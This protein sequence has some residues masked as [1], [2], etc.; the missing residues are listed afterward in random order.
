M[1]PFIKD[2]LS[3]LQL[4]LPEC[5]YCN[6]AKCRVTSGWMERP[7]GTWTGPRVN[8]TPMEVSP[9]TM[10]ALFWHSIRP[11]Y[12]CQQLWRGKNMAVFKECREAVIIEEGRKK[13]TLLLWRHLFLTP[14]INTICLRI[15]LWSL[16][17]F[18]Q[19]FPLESASVWKGSWFLFL[20][21]FNTHVHTLCEYK[22][23]VNE[24]NHLAIAKKLN[25]RCW[26]F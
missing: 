18:I 12:I 26:K 9:Q 4:I 14:L 19:H 1:A 11:I 25:R 22:S 6:F 23:I 24:Q 17:N 8:L 2:G 3:P 10:F 21:I 13:V 20:F 7:L 15:N 16:T 5:V